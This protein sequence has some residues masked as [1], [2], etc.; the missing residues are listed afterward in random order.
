MTEGRRL[1]VREGLDAKADLLTAVAEQRGDQPARIG[2]S[3]RTAPRMVGSR[4][5]SGRIARA[6]YRIA[7]LLSAVVPNEV[8]RADGWPVD[9]AESIK[10]LVRNSSGKYE[11]RSIRI[12]QCDRAVRGLPRSPQLLH[13]LPDVGIEVICRLG[14][15]ARTE[16]L[17]ESSGRDAERNHDGPDVIG[18]AVPLPSGLDFDFVTSL[19]ERGLDRGELVGSRV[20][21]RRHAPDVSVGS[22]GGIVPGLAGRAG[23][24][25]ARFPSVAC[26]IY[27]LAAGASHDR[28]VG[29]T[30]EQRR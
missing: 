11:V 23:S 25:P 8:V 29:T 1:V 18:G 14:T 26:A 27:A 12:V 6:A 15:E 2:I 24:R 7:P 13:P 3:D 9:L 21:V 5:A 22:H 17:Q 16:R 10:S 4:A 19:S 30:V 20:P 28:A